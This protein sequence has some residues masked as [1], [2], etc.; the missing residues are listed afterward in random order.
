MTRH[1]ILW[2]ALTIAALVIGA[3]V[4]AVALLWFVGL[5]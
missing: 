5:A 3:V 2:Q 4:L 1:S